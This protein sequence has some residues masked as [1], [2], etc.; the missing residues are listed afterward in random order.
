MI[1]KLLVTQG[2]PAG[3]ALTFGPGEYYFGRGEECH[4]RFNSDWVSRQHCLLVVGPDQVMLTDLGSRNGTL[5]NGRLL[6]Q[7]K[8]LREGDQV[9]I[10]PVVFEVRLGPEAGGPGA[11][12]HATIRAP[13]EEELSDAV[14]LDTTAQR[15]A[16]G[17]DKPPG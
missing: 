12:I 8:A 5:L 17:V 10:G 11:A 13:G 16:L 4:V 1:V 14:P 9:H 6:Q 7:E 15:P 2:R 3:K